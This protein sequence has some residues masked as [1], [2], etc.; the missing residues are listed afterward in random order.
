MNIYIYIY[1]IAKHRK[2]PLAKQWN[3]CAMFSPG[4]PKSSRQKWAW[5]HLP[6]PSM[7]AIHGND[8]CMVT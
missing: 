6:Q 8:S 2:R 7:A 1:M 5:W 3:S 4:F